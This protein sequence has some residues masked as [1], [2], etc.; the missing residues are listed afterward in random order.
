MAENIPVKNGIK[1]DA[2]GRF[3]KGNRGGGRTKG[4]IDLWPEFYKAMRKVEKKKRINMFEHGWRLALDDNKLF[5]AML[6][7]VVPDLTNEVGNRGPTTIYIIHADE[8][9]ALKVRNRV[10]AFATDGNGG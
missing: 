9:P 3:V 1:Q 6:K 2:K 8:Q 4:V 10:A 7:K 5:A